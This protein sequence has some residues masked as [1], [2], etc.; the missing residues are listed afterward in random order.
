M[1]KKLIIKFHPSVTEDEILRIRNN[2]H[3]DF[4]K[5]TNQNITSLIAKCEAFLVTDFSTTILDAAI[6]KKPIILIQIMNFSKNSSFF[7]YLLTIERNDVEKTL[8]SLMDDIEFRNSIIAR[9]NAF[10]S[11][12]LVNGGKSSKILADYLIERNNMATTN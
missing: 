9:G 8:R 1:N 12:Y 6:L 4:I 7:Q 3:C 5:I 11:Y 2:Y 10:L